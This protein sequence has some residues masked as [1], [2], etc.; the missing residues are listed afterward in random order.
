MEERVVDLGLGIEGAL[1]RDARPKPGRL[2]RWVGRNNCRAG[3][4]LASRAEQVSS[5]LRD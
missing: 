3:I 4:I 5:A 2:N 1:T